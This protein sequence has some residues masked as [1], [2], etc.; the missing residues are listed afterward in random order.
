MNGLTL[1]FFIGSADDNNNILSTENGLNLFINDETI[2][3]ITS[4]GIQ[5][6]T[7]FTTNIDIRKITIKK[8]QK[9]YSECTSD[10]T[11]VNAYPSECYKRTFLPNKI[12]HYNDCT[13]TCLQK[14]SFFSN[15]FKK[16]YLKSSSVQFCSS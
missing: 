7:G 16:V 15:F 8:Q 13:K 10:L 9:P 4:E 1:E 5:I 12:Y 14:V 2:D 11:T 6:P 3:S